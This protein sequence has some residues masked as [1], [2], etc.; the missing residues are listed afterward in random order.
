[1]GAE[2][3]RSLPLTAVIDASSMTRFWVRPH[4]PLYAVV[5]ARRSSLN[6]G[7]FLTG[8]LS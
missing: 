2:V 4:T 7:T 8:A 5:T 3:A 6:E 1:V